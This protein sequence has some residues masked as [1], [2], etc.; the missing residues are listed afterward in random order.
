MRLSPT[1]AEVLGLQLDDK[2]FFL[3]VEQR[4]NG[5]RDNSL[6]DGVADARRESCRKNAREKNELGIVGRRLWR[7]LS[8]GG[9]EARGGTRCL[10]ATLA[11]KSP[12]ATVAL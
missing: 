8:G 6:A 2:A 5:A 9:R 1:R 4:F 3:A 10:W 12:M 11:H 7:V